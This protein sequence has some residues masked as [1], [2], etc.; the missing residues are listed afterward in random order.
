M[1]T[2]EGLASREAL[3]GM[4]AEVFLHC[5]LS[6]ARHRGPLGQC[7]RPQRRSGF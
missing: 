3:A 5:G 1:P 7:P 6:P 2:P 4:T